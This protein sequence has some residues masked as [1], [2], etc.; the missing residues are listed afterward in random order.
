MTYESCDPA[1][2]PMLES[3]FLHPEKIACLKEKPYL[4]FAAAYLA[5]NSLERCFMSKDFVPGGK[6]GK[7]VKSSGVLRCGPHIT[8]LLYPRCF[9]SEADG[10]PVDLKLEPVV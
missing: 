5:H 8:S 1:Y 3:V 4:S 9:G 10:P 2:T 6:V 7:P